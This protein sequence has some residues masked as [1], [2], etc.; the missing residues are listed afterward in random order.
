MTYETTT[1]IVWCTSW[2]GEYNTWN[3]KV[4][5]DTEL[6]VLIFIHQLFIVLLL[7]YCES[8]LNYFI[9]HMLPRWISR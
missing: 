9:L 2:L 3:T 5:A 7:A 4:P 8:I 6:Q 1:T